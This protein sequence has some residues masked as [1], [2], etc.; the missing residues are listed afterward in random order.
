[1]ARPKL[2]QAPL[3]PNEGRSHS[4]LL[5]SMFE[6]TCK[7]NT[8]LILSPRSDAFLSQAQQGLVDYDSQ[9]MCALDRWQPYWIL[10][11]ENSRK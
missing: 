8:G 1:M 7:K 10:F 2:R 5:S 4:S 3:R 11:P 9:C 6:E